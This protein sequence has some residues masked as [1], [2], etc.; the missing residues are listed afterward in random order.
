M[1]T[2]ARSATSRPVCCTEKTKVSHDAAWADEAEEM[3]IMLDED[4]KKTLDNQEQM[5]LEVFYDRIY[6]CA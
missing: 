4:W 6:C 1:N 3:P 2:S 5:G